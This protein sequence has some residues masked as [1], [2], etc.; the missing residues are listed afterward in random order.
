MSLPSNPV[1]PRRKRKKRRTRPKVTTRRNSFTD[2]EIVRILLDFDNV[3]NG[4]I[5]YYSN[6]F[7][8]LNNPD[9]K[10]DIKSELALKLTAAIRNRTIQLFK[11]T[12]S[13]MNVLI[14]RM[15]NNLIIDRLREVK[16]GH[17]DSDISI[18]SHDHG[19]EESTKGV[20]LRAG[21]TNI[22][23]SMQI[24]I[25][26]GGTNDNAYRSFSYDDNIE[27]LMEIRS[28]NKQ[29]LEQ[30]DPAN[31]MLYLRLLRADPN[32][33]GPQIRMNSPSVIRLKE[34][35][36]AILKWIREQE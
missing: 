20:V 35:V 19:G 13:M 21:N 33:D 22:V 7:S 14:Q 6:Q 8:C 3:V 29:V 15:V 2:S 28:L 16:K 18:A 10:A 11:V 5:A 25:A 1:R 36:K 32:G 27:Y 17:H 26:G 30:L 23:A 34:E 24:E 9:A 12:D 4:R 31:R